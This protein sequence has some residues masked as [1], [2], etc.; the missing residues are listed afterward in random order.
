MDAV[1]ALSDRVSVLVSGEIIATDT[2][3]NIRKD[4]RVRIAYLGEDA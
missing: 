3:A 2:V 4:E 1:F